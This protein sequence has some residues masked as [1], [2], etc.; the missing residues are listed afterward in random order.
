MVAG[1]SGRRKKREMEKL[2]YE[3][4]HGLWVSSSRLQGI[5]KSK[6]GGESMIMEMERLS[7]SVCFYFT[8]FFFFVFSLLCGGISRADIR[9]QIC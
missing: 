8:F 1:E 5:E 4:D 3:Y 6:N 2:S 9:C 7:L